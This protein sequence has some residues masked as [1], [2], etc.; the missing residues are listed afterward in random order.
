[1]LADAYPELIKE[2]HPTKNGN[3][4]P[5]NT[6]LGKHEKSWWILPYDDPETG[7]HYEF[8]WDDYIYNRI[9]GRGC[10]F[11]SG[12]RVYKGYNDLATRYPEL[13]REWHP[14]RNSKSADEVTWGSGDI[15]WW[16][17]PYDDPKTGKHFDFEWEAKI[18]N[19][20]HG[21]KCPFLSGKAVWPGYNDLSTTNPE[22]AKEWHLTKNEQPAT[23]VSAG[24]QDKVWWYLPY[25]DPVTGKHFEFEWEAAIYSRTGKNPLG[26]PYISGK[27][28]WKGYNDLETLIPK[29]AK[30]W[31]PT[32][33]RKKASEVTCYCNDKVW[34]YL[35]Y[36][37]P[38]T[39]KH[40]DFEWKASISHRTNGRG[41]PFL[42]SEEVWPGYNDLE[43]KMPEVA[44]EWHPRKNKLMAHQVMPQ[45][46]K[47]AWWY[48]PYDDPKTGKHFD[49]EWYGYISDRCRGYGCPYLSGKAV[50]PGYNDLATTHPEVA[51]QWHPTKNKKKVTEVS[52]GLP[53]KAWWYLPYDDPKTG[54]HFDFEWDSSINKR[55][56]GEQCPY[57]IGRRV[58]KG[59]NDLETINPK[60]AGQWHPTRNKKSPSEVTQYSNDKVWWRV[61]YIDPSGRENVYEWPASVNSRSYGTDCPFFSSS[62]T[63][64]LVYALL[65]RKKMEFIAEKKFTDCRDKLPLP[66]D[67]YIQSKNLIIELDGIQHFT[68]IFY[69]N[70]ENITMPHDCIKNKY[71]KEKGIKLL[72]IPYIFNPIKDKKKI[73]QF[74]DD[75]ICSGTISQEIL[76]FYLNN[77]ESNYYKL[78]SN[79]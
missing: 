25:D 70:Y 27:A 14:T 54:K 66:F 26:C 55:A 50:W 49:F 18:S 75:F 32:K 79:Q 59:F 39:G 29:L 56:L 36:D 72:R 60:L 64:R 15:V 33:N 21:R 48:L 68:N 58:W 13:A 19:R 30:E 7:K 10:P 40:F 23:Q 20:I 37:D 5:Y 57:L 9:K 35:P 11:I 3:N 47:K 28:V 6:S 43:T 4:T 77:S 44:K 42:S 46:N 52:A 22:I 17:L 71:C 65:K 69:N 24:S 31:H 78:F 74:V 62:K 12:K 67:V 38:A 53:N 45:S 1:M 16:Y 2:W 51:K 34:W 41:C 73:E 63:E 76:N 61:V 8:E